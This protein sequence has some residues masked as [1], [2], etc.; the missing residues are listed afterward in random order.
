M[1]TN[2]ISVSP[3]TKIVEVAQILFKNRI[4]AVPVVEEGKVVGIIA[5]DDFFTRDTN[6]VFLPSYIEFIKGTKIVDALVKEKQEK[7]SKLMSLEAKD[8]MTKECVSILEDMDLNGLLEFFRE[9][10]FMTLPVIDNKEKLIGIV[11]VSDII[12][13]MKA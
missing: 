11:T 6:N 7:L 2:V 9:T 4:H 10:R 12:G 3:D 8:I 1:I 5:E 13:L